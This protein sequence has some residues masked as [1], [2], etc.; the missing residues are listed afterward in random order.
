MRGDEV[1]GRAALD[2]ARRKSLSSSS[3]TNNDGKSSLLSAHHFLCL[4]RP[5]PVCVV[6]ESFFKRRVLGNMS[7]HKTESKWVDPSQGVTIEKKAD[8]TVSEIPAPTG[9][10]IPQ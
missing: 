10:D 3:T 4:S 5:P 1:E 8:T 7:T 9:E 6:L 2:E